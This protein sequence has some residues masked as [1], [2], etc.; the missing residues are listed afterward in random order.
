MQLSILNVNMKNIIKTIKDTDWIFLIFLLLFINQSNFSLKTIGIIFI[1][2]L[3]PNIKFGLNKGRIPKFYL[4]IILLALFNLFINIRDFSYPYL[5]AFSMASLLW[6]YC[7][8]AYH[9]LKLSVEKFV[10]RNNDTLK[11]FTFLNFIVS[12]FQIVRI[13]LIT[14]KIN[15][16]RGLDFPYGLSTGDHVFGIFFENAYL[17]AMTCSLLAIYFLYKKNYIF[18]VLA[19]T[20]LVLVFVNALTFI[21]IIILLLILFANII[22]SK[23]KFGCLKNIILDENY[24]LIIPFTILYIFI[25]S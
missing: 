20:T 17:N 8:L 4:L 14:M 24:Y 5:I 6:V 7:F 19:V 15:P 9:Q 23:L 3:R 22:Y 1:Y 12:I 16:Y 10:N 13:M 2:V 18:L 11:V 25:I 21:F